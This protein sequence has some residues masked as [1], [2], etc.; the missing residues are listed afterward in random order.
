MC[1][2]FYALTVCATAASYNLKC[3]K[4]TNGLLSSRHANIW[5]SELS[6]LCATKSRSCSSR[7][8]MSIR[9]M[10][11]SSSVAMFTANSTICS[12]YLKLVE[13]YRN[14][15]T[16]LSGISWI[17][18]ITQSRPSNCCSVTNLST[19]RISSSFEETTSLA[20]SPLSTVS[21]NK[22]PKSMAA[23]HRGN[24]STMPSIICP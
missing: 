2:L 7:S 11:R 18:A 9:L 6:A 5:K 14:L 21:T 17:A 12:S 10:H 24:T 22:S 19:R 15:V 3:R 8:P 16:F 23:Q 13:R 1:Y 4:S 20:K